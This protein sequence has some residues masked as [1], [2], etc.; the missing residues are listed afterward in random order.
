MIFVSRLFVSRYH[1]WEDFR[2]RLFTCKDRELL[3]FTS[4][5]G[6]L[7]FVQL[8][9]RPCSRAALASLWF[10]Q[11][12]HSSLL[13]LWRISLSSSWTK[14]CKDPS[15]S[16]RVW[17]V[18]ITRLYN[19]CTTIHWL[20]NPI[21]KPGWLPWGKVIYSFTTLVQVPNF[22]FMF[23]VWSPKMLV[24]ESVRTEMTTSRG[25]KPPYIFIEVVLF[26]YDFTGL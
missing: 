14:I 22:Q 13:C 9:Y 11:S 15:N 18:V 12:C 23:L 17:D 19:W 16:S 1:I 6:S 2:A 3:T 5:N 10:L 24:L 26:C 21:S 8:Q 7:V 4:G 25:Y 20:F